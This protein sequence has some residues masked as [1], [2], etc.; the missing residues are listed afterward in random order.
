M[1]SS[2]YSSKL[3]HYKLYFMQNKCE[4]TK[5]IHIGLIGI[6]VVALNFML[7]SMKRL[8]LEKKTIPEQQMLIVALSRWRK[9]LQ[10]SLKMG[11]L[12]I[13]KYRVSLCDKPEEPFQVY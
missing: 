11:K 7:T 2:M 3:Q 12:A 10:A 1:M 8:K 6:S 13:H 5:V 4:R 9:L